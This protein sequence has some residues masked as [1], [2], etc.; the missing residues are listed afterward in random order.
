LAVADLDFWP[1][2]VLEA[3]TAGHDRGPADVELHFRKAAREP[4]QVLVQQ[5]VDAAAH[6]QERAGRGLGRRRQA[7]AEQQGGNQWSNAQAHG[8]SLMHIPEGGALSAPE[9][10]L[11]ADKR[12]YGDVI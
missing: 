2:A 9:D 5:V 6:R 10:R 11:T 12:P 7:D 8:F 1:Q 3:V 4:R